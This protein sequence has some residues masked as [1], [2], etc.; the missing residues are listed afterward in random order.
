MWT[1]E[2]S[3]PGFIEDAPVNGHIELAAFGDF[4]FYVD[5]IEISKVPAYVEIFCDDGCGEAYRMEPL[6]FYRD[7]L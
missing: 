5:F 6:G 3:Q 4:G 2:L 7:L 1:V